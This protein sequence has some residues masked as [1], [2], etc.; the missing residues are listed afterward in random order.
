MPEESPKTSNDSEPIIKV[1][2]AVVLD[3]DY[4]PAGKRGR[5]ELALSHR[6]L[7]IL[8]FILGSGLYRPA[9]K[10]VTG[11]IQEELVIKVS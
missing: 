5:E 6:N 9:G 4:R 10:R 1:A 11:F 2:K 3:N 8:I 7:C